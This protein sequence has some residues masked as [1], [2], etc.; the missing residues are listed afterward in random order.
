MSLVQDTGGRFVDLDTDTGEFY[1]VSHTEAR[2]KVSQVS[3]QTPNREVNETCFHECRPTC[4]SLS[5]VFGGQAL[6]HRR[7][8]LQ[9]AQQ[10]GPNCSTRRRSRDTNAPPMQD[11]QPIPLN[12]GDPQPFRNENDLAVVEDI[13]GLEEAELYWFLPE[14]AELCKHLDD[15]DT[16]WL[17]DV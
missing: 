3:S 13:E 4:L 5:C 15:T 2:M 12:G 9:R 17:E 11:L 14:A 6:R 10:N 7:I 1:E 16:M 8:A